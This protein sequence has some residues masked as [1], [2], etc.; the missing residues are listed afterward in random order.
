MNISKHERPPWLCSRSPGRALA[1]LLQA[2]LKIGRGHHPSATT[3]SV[4]RRGGDARPAPRQPPLPAG[5]QAVDSSGRVGEGDGSPSRRKQE[6]L[7]RSRRRAG[8]W[9]VRGRRAE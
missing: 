7:V 2:V 9:G 3:Q 1:S 6:L 4:A 8:R 5:L